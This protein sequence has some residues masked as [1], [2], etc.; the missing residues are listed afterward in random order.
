[1]MIAS[2]LRVPAHNL[3]ASST[4]TEDAWLTLAAGVAQVRKNGHDIDWTKF[5]KEQEPA[6]E[7]V[8]L[9]VVNGLRDTEEKQNVLSK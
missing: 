2:T 4:K 5:N 8:R 3:I 9:S 1:M 6:Q 7:R